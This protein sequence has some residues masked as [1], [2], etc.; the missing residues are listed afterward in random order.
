MTTL[1]IIIPHYNSVEELKILLSS[2]PDNKN[3]QTIIVDDKSTVDKESYNKLKKKLE[4]TS[5]LFLKNKTNKKGAG[6]CRNIALQHADGQWILFADSDDFFMEDF[7]NLISPYFLTEYDIIYFR[8][9]SLDK[10]T[11]KVSDRHIEY[12][13]II[14]NYLENPSME[15]ENNLRFKYYVPWSKLISREFIER[16]DIKFDEVIVAN[17]VMF[18]TKV[19]YYAEEFD[20]SSEVIYCVTRDKGSLTTKV[21]KK[22]FYS[23]LYVWIDF[24][25][26]LKRRLI[27]KEFEALN[28]NGRAFLIRAIKYNF[29]LKEIINIYNILRENKVKLFDKKILNPVFL[30]KIIKTHYKEYNEEKKYYSE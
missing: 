23:R 24:Y 27:K 22:A 28:L 18:S 5:T 3:I 10:K 1:S 11:D 20:V 26:F 15:T 25:N 9:T 14:M 30:F 19:G 12:E 6:V 4:N 16:N 17:D 2:I 29:N 21:N 7:Y 13:N 8:P